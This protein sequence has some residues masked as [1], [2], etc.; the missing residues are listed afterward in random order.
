MPALYFKD[1]IATT[2]YRASALLGWSLAVLGTDL[3][4][5]IFKRHSAKTEKKFQKQ[6]NI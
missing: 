1:E 5:T 6:K 2:V 4:A 3:A